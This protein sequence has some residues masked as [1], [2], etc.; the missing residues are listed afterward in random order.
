MTDMERLEKA[1]LPYE[2]RL[3]AQ[4]RFRKFLGVKEVE[5][6]TYQRYIT[7]PIERFEKQRMAFL[8]LRPGESLRLGNSQKIQSTNW[9]RP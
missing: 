9:F 3:K 7:G 4:E 1:L 5:Q 8:A 2:K 6:P